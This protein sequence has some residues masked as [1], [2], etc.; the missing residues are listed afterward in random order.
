M[1][2]TRATVAA[3][4][5]LVGV[6][7]GLGPGAPR[8][9][10]AIEAHRMS[11]ER[12][13]VST[14]ELDAL[15]AAL[16]EVLDLA[17]DGAAAVRSGD[18]PPGP[19]LLSA[20]EGLSA[21]ATVARRAADAIAALEAARRA[22][23]PE[24]VLLPAGIDPDELGSIAVQLAGTAAAADEFAGMRGRAANVPVRLDAALAAL[25]DGDLD[26]AEAALA[27]ARADHAA[28]AG[29]DAGFA[30]LPIWAE[31]A[32]ATI[33][34]VERLIRAIRDDDNEAADRA[35]ADFANLSDA[36]IHADR[37]LQIAM[38]EGAGTVTAAPLSR[39]VRA[40]DAVADQRAALGRLYSGTMSRH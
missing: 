21:A 25:T 34:A 7:L 3:V 33:G 35:A 26:A 29:W 13:A 38:S 24:A 37:A 17:R 23:S 31:T 18:D 12:M 19:T 28:V 40:I 9:E 10:I 14:A 22:E 6:T 8:P 16:D 30:T 27:L 36:A 1:I 20:S 2:G 11:V 4:T 15:A 5:T 39:L 32:G